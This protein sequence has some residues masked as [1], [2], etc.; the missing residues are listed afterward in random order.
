M[1]DVV[2]IF[3]SWQFSFQSLA[4]I[5]AALL[6]ILALAGLSRQA[7]AQRGNRLGMVGMA[8]VLV[9]TIIF[10][11][12]FA[13]ENQLTSALLI[14]LALGIGA[15]VGIPLARKVEMTGM[16][17]L[18]AMLHSFVGLAAVLVGYN[19]FIIVPGSDSPEN[20]FHMG[21]VGLAVFIGAVT[22]TGSIIA[23]LK[24]SGRMS[25]RPLTLP[26]RNWLNL[27]A[28]LASVVLIVWFAYTRSLAMGMI[29][30]V[31]LTIVALLLG[32]HLVAAIG[33]G[34]MP[35]VVSMLNSYSG[36]AAAMAGFTL[37]NDLLIIVGALVGSS[38]AY[39]SYIMCQAMNRSFISVIL[40]GFGSDGGVA[41]ERDYGSHREISAAEVADM[42][43][44]A[45]KVVITPGYGMAVAQ[46]QYPVADLTRRLRD[47]G[48][49]VSFAIHPVA[50]RLPGHMNV[51]L[52]EANVP[53]DIVYEMDEVND[54]LGEADVVL[55]IGANDTVNP[56]AEEPGS[57]IAG[58]PVVKVWEAKNVIVFK[59]SMGNAGYAGVQNPLFFNENTQML[60]GDAKESVNQI[61]AAL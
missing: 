60:L 59:R 16:P 39:L 5:A 4:Y 38:G 23:Y 19:S 12:S 14:V 50:G 56:S 43:K 41:E 1:T 28:L 45:H 10:V 52:A 51:L 54:S 34:D 48:V 29:P 27:G 22:F 35:V 31:L 36:W 40:G 18:I 47:L 15:G 26:G 30:L 8:L 2:N 9:A 7:T 46:A 17:E 20:A 13:G 55:V 11:I 57:P 3:N 24:L 49:D 25:G 44:D 33:G 53:Y 61:N 37:G 6:F 21:E 58:M 32:L 42:L